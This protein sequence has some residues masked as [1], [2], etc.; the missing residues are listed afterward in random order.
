MV[1]VL[2]F[3]FWV[4]GKIMILYKTD[5]AFPH[6]NSMGEYY[7]DDGFG[8]PIRSSPSCYKYVR[9]FINEELH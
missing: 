8:N 3:G 9:D 1:S 2:P 4:K 6:Y 7:Q 5:Y